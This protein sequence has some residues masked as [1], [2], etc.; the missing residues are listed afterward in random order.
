MNSGPPAK[1]SRTASDPGRKD[2]EVSH[3]RREVI[4]QIIV[5]IKMV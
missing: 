1:K 5:S 4:N 2:A 3:I